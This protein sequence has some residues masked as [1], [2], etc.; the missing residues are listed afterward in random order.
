MQTRTISL[1]TVISLIG[2]LTLAGCTGKNS[3]DATQTDSSS[4]S[5]KVLKM[6]R[7]VYD[8]GN[9][10]KEEGDA[11]DNKWTQ[12]INQKSGIEVTNVPFPRWEQT[13]MLPTKFASGSAPDLIMEY[14]TGFINTLWAQGQL[15]PIDDLIEQHSVNYKKLLEQYPALRKAGLM[16][17]GKLYAVG[18]IAYVEPQKTL[19]IRKDWLDKLKLEV[20]KTIEEMITVAKAFATMDPDGNNKA[21][22]YGINISGDG[23]WMIPGYFGVPNGPDDNHYI[24]KDGQ[25]VY[26]W[27]NFKDSIAFEKQLFDAGAVN[28][29]FLTDKNGQLARQDF[30]QGKMGMY[31]ISWGSSD[32][33]LYKDFKSNNPDGE[34]IVMELP[35]SKYGR[36]SPASS[37]AISING[38]VNKSAK[39]PEAVIKYI[40]F[41]SDPANNARMSYGYKDTNYKIA[42]NGSPQLIA[43]DVNKNTLSYNADLT[44][45]LRSSYL[46][47]EAAHYSNQMDTS[48]PVVGA[49]K[50][51]ND[52]ATELYLS[53]KN[54]FPPYIQLSMLP[55]DLQQIADSV[56]AQMVN[57]WNKAIVSGA[58]YTPDMA[59][60]DNQKIWEGVG[61]NKV[62]AYYADWF[63]ENK[64]N[65]IMPEDN[66]QFVNPAKTS[67]FDLKEWAKNDT[68]TAPSVS[69]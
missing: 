63:A 8:R 31:N 34:Y 29:D 4:K 28:K 35:E 9:T 10:P 49:V 33:S 54:P 58:K 55:A 21:D 50:K 57:N 66:L 11:A 38:V 17:D 48:D 47:G 52:K 64:N 6:S 30:L 62:V 51:I 42:D 68:E 2:V 32:T 40:D 37:N 45:M 13:K 5:A 53:G 1:L 24:I 59:L 65:I 25:L 36:F 26:G 3:G 46:F 44:W 27:D 20:P 12:W 41:M 18:R 19:L 16:P 22:T 67:N 43:G 39:D 14:D 56:R 60:K 61:G 69:K 7:T 23:E 15:Q